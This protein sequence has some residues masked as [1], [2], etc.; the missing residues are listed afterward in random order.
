MFSKNVEKWRA[1]AAAQLAAHQIPLP[2]DLVL[3]VMARESKGKIG[4]VNPKSGAAGLMQIMPIALADYNQ[5]NGTQYT[6]DDMSATDDAGAVKQIAVGVGTIGHFWKS[7][8]HYMNHRYGG[9]PVQIEEL[10]RIAD[11]FYVAGPGGARAKLDTVNP[12]LWANVQSAYPNWS[13]LNHPKH[14]FAEQKPWNLGAIQGWLDSTVK[15]PKKGAWAL[16]DPK[17]GMAVAVVILTVVYYFMKG[18]PK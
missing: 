11:L 9:S 2:V 14:V 4:D 18:R 16:D 3:A 12:P 10:A 17:T 5:R 1:T 8:Y 13:A 15:T 7:A 6:M